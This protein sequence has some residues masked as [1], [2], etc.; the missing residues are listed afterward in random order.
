MTFGLSSVGPPPTFDDDPAVRE[1][2]HCRLAGE[3]DLAAENVAVE[4][5]DAFDVRGDDEVGERDSVV[6]SA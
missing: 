4:A 5:G 1:R 6:A 3:N 2:D